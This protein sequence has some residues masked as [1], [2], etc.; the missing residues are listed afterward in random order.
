MSTHG[1]IPQNSID[2]EPNYAGG[3]DENHNLINI[4]I[5]NSCN[6]SKIKS[7]KAEALSKAADERYPIFFN[8][9][10]PD[11]KAPPMTN[12]KNDPKLSKIAEDH[13]KDPPKKKNSEKPSKSN[14]HLIKKFQSKKHLIKTM[15]NQ[16]ITTGS[17]TNPPT[18]PSPMITKA[19]PPSTSVYTN[20][21]GPNRPKTV[22]AQY[23]NSSLS[24]GLKNK[25]IRGILNNFTGTTNGPLDYGS[26]KGGIACKRSPKKFTLGGEGL[27]SGKAKRL[28]G[29]EE[30]GSGGERFCD[31]NVNIG[32]V[33]NRMVSGSGYNG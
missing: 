2:C 3:N 28:V 9:P 22:R 5:V 31:E 20:S 4:D 6:H 12:K 30:G 29:G 21:T 15:V 23:S 16:Q 7:L 8:Q 13:A 33:G 10:R 32:N 27:K 25:S 17:P 26:P 19:I 18:G 14:D 24:T 1:R 11:R